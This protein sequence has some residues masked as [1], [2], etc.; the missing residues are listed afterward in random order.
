MTTK[1][2]IEIASVPHREELVA[3]LWYGD[4]QWGELSQEGGHLVL[5]IYPNPAGQPWSFEFP[6]VLDALNQARY[7]LIGELEQI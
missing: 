3:E 1:I 7:R 6:E 5:E 4:T 2:T